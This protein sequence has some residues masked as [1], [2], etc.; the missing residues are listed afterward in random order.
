MGAA[1]IIWIVSEGKKRAGQADAAS[2]NSE[3][4]KPKNFFVR[5]KAL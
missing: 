1:S 3:P 4:P 5:K 2:V